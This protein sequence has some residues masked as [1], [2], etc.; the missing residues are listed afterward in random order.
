MEKR[1]AE[2]INHKASVICQHSETKAISARIQD[3]NKQLTIDN[4]YDIDNI[5]IRSFIRP[6]QEFNMLRTQNAHF[7]ITTIS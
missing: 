2:P 5:K 4:K 1:A 7:T 3:D 6:I